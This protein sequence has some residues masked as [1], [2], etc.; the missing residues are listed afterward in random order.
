MA[1]PTLADI[2]EKIRELTASQTE[3]QLSTPKMRFLVASFYEN[4]LPAEFR[5]LKLLDIYTFNTVRGVSTYPFDSVN[6]T[7]LQAPAK[8]AKRN[9]LFTDDISTYQG[10]AT[11]YSQQFIEQIATANGAGPYSYTTQNQP[12]L[13]SVNNDPSVLTY[14]AGRV[15]NILITG[16]NTSQTFNVTDDGN[17]VLIGDCLAGGTINYDTGAIANLTFTGSP[18]AGSAINIQYFPINYRQPLNILFYQ[19]QLTLFPVPDQGYTVEIQ[20]YRTPTQVLLNTPA[21][22]GIPELK[23]WWELIAVG[24]AKKFY[25]NKIDSDGIQLMNALLTEKYSIAEARTY[26]QIGSDRVKTIYTDQLNGLGYQGFT[27]YYNGY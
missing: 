1:N 21:D 12:L 6:Y 14:P 16:F 24:G 23:E 20:A 15:Q 11:Y 8:I 2:F 5:S 19:N 9:V 7:T 13:R 26:A 18:T 27:G 10:Y 22:Q 17:G 4:D 3:N 25:E